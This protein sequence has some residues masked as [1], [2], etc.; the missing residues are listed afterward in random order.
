[1]EMTVFSGVRGLAVGKLQDEQGNS[2][3]GKE[4]QEV[5]SDGRG[6]LLA[7]LIYASP[8]PYFRS[9][10]CLGCIGEDVQ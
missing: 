6:H 5:E 7:A 1:M 9:Y 10:H 4:R 2:G 3:A 8:L